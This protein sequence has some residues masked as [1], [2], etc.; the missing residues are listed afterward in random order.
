MDDYL[1]RCI[2]DILFILSE[3]K[4]KDQLEDYLIAFEIIDRL[5]ADGN[6]KKVIRVY[7]DYDLDLTRI[8]TLIDDK[9]LS[10]DF[11]YAYTWFINFLSDKIYKVKVNSTRLK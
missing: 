9:E 5:V 1:I 3:D 2:G 8:M 11:C 7:F 4:N 10:L 6:Y